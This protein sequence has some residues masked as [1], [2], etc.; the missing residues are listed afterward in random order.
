MG[1][2]VI[3]ECRLPVTRTSAIRWTA[4]QS[5]C[6]PHQPRPEPPHTRIS[7]QGVEHSVRVPSACQV[8]TVEIVMRQR[9]KRPL[10][11]WRNPPP[12]KARH[13]GPVCN[14]SAPD[15]ERQ[16]VRPDIPVL[17]EFRRSP[18]LRQDEY[19]VMHAHQAAHSAASL[20]RRV[21]SPVSSVVPA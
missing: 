8:A 10:A 6:E 13:T 19:R 7:H 15:T 17:V 4:E 1:G 2:R 16:T 5:Y 12:Q 18:I 3:T 21:T 9:G 14:E 20:A 11:H